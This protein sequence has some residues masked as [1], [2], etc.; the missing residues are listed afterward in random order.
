MYPMCCSLHMCKVTQKQFL[1]FCKNCPLNAEK[2]QSLSS[3]HA[4]LVKIGKGG[5]PK[6]LCG[7][8]DKKVGCLRL[9]AF[10]MPLDG[11]TAVILPKILSSPPNN[12]QN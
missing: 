8:S 5:V 11:T 7:I 9:R 1:L 3:V 6:T 10:L 12:F 2:C 4:N